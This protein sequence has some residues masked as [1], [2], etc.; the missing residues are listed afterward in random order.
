M[1]ATMQR[2][3]LMANALIMLFT[4]N[5]CLATQYVVGGNQ[6]WDLTSDLN[7]WESDKTFN[8]GDSLLFK[9]TPGLHSVVEVGSE[10]EY[11]SCNIGNPVNSLN[12]G[13]N[14]VKLGKAGTRYFVCG[15]MGHCSGGMKLKVTVLPQTPKA[16][17][18]A[19]A[20]TTSADQSAASPFVSFIVFLSFSLMVLL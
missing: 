7:S 15:T 19:T 11:K 12:G 8:V 10:A 17:T 9:Y 20:S 16:T 14:V 4:T 18:S 1:A 5:S 13:N 2:M 6:G 3:A